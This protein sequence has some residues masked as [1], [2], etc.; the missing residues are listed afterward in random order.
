M[1]EGQSL[2]A[3]VQDLLERL[4]KG[5]LR[6]GFRD[7]LTRGSAQGT[8]TVVSESNDDPQPLLLV[9]FDIMRLP[10]SNA[11]SLFRRLLELNGDLCGRAAFWVSRDGLVC[12]QAGRPLE[13]LDA[14]ELIDLI[15]WTADQADAY[16]D[17]LLEEFGQAD[18]RA[19]SVTNFLEL[20]VLG[21]RVP[22]QGA[23]QFRD[24]LALVAKRDLGFVQLR[25]QLLILG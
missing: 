3:L 23:A 8:V 10:T 19:L 13:D 11:E 16:D 2:A 24:T 6:V 21:R 5:Q 18:R 17:V 9:T 22:W 20:N 15:M 1:I 4:A 7:S 14:G 12:L 25:S